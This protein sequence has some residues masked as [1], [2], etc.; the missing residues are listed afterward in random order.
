MLAI[1]LHLRVEISS[2]ETIS[3]TNNDNISTSAY[4]R[5]LYADSDASI[6]ELLVKLTYGSSQSEY[7]RHLANASGLL[8]GSKLPNTWKDVLKMMTDPGYRV[9]Q[10]VCS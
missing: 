1:T 3:E 4:S 5:S 9:L 10:G 2:S 7:E 8:S 6:I